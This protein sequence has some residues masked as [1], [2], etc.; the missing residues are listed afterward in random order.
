[1]AVAI[2]VTG[3]D[4]CEAWADGIEEGSARGRGAAVVGDLEQVPASAVIG[5]AL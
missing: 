5:D 1:M 4:G 2:A 3:A